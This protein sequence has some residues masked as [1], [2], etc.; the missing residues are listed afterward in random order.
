[1]TDNI[2]AEIEDK[3]IDCINSGVA[4]R[5]VIFK[6]QKNS[7][8]AN[9]AVERRGKYKEGE[10]YFQ[11][12]SLAEP[13]QDNR[14][15]KDF[16]QKSFKSEKGFYLLFVYFDEV[17]QRIDDHVWLIP[18]LQF[19]DIAVVVGLPN[20]EKALR[21]EAS[22][23]FKDKNSYS[24]FVVSTAELG[25]FILEA[26]E[27]GG[28]F[29]F[30]ET[31]FS[32]KEGI[33]LS[34]LKEFLCDARENTYASDG[35]S[36]DNPRLMSSIQLEFQKGNYFYRDIYFLGKKKF[37]GQEIIYQDSKPIWGMNYMGA[38]IGKVETDFLK[39]SLYKLADKCRIG[40]DCEYTKREF[41]YQDKGQ[42]DVGEFSGTEEIFVENK[43]VYRLNYQG[44]L[45][46]DKL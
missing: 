46:S 37:I 45:I 13:A 12:N 16:S 44:G 11:I 24:K 10:M 40:G 19:R 4:G 36:I 22:A 27:R 35:A 28:K 20:G 38:D 14:V 5:L 39:E 18:S 43:S 9:L 21:F 33:N 32:E 29:D 34:S 17:R 23:D 6:P 30:K 7:F 2:Q 1:M 26:F 42:G 15:V 3:V 31:E 8:G 25:K 41:K